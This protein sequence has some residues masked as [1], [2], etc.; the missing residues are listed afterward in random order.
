MIT[1]SGNSH[2][3]RLLK[4]SACGKVHRWRF[5]NMTRQRC[6]TAGGCMIWPASGDSIYIYTWHGL[7]NFLSLARIRNDAVRLPNFPAERR[8]RPRPPSPLRLP[9]R[10]PW[11]PGPCPGAPRRHPRGPRPFSRGP[12]PRRRPRSPRRSTTSSPSTTAP[13]PYQDGLLL[14]AGRF[15]NGWAGTAADCSAAADSAASARHRHLI[16]SP[17][18]THGGRG[19]GR[20]AATTAPAW[21]VF[22]L[23][24]FKMQLHVLKMWI[25]RLWI[26]GITWI[27]DK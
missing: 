1:A 7:E 20:G 23:F 22:F 10:L 27:V 15:P 26:N 24:F 21:L 18:G 6:S 25:N 14:P 11:V 3:W 2:H 9:R 19:W 5:F 12:P 13:L 4:S 17:L 16:S 8:R